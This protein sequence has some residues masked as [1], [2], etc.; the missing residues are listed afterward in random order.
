MVQRT[1]Y[2]KLIDK[3]IKAKEEQQIS[4]QKTSQ[5]EMIGIQ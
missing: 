3:K 1:A 4:K 5:Q 2:G